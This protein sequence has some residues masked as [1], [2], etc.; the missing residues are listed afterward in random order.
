MRKLKKLTDKEQQ[1]IEAFQK[2]GGN[3]KNVCNELNISLNTY[4][5]YLSKDIVKERINNSLQE[6]RQL[7]V[8]ATPHIVN[9]A[10]KM[11]NDKNL[12][13]KYKIQIINSLLDRAGIIEPKIS[14]VSININTQISE[15]ARQLLSETLT[16]TT[17]IS[18]TEVE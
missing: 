18:T 13:E 6:A 3:A 15:R 4:N 11:L 16:P 1:F 8:N 7:I 12:N 10:I 14:P 5:Y 17:T 9:E 2:Y